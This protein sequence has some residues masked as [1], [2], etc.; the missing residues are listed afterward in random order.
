MKRFQ[1]NTLTSTFGIPQGEI[2]ASPMV[3][4]KCGYGSKEEKFI[5]ILKTGYCEICKNQ[6]GHITLKEWRTRNAV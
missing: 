4:T 5:P 1:Q 2:A 6:T 3:C